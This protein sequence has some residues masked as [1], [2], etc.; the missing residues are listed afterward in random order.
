MN[1]DDKTKS[2]EKTEKDK[3]L[4]GELYYSADPELTRDRYKAKRQMWK[5]NTIT[6]LKFSKEE[7]LEE[8]MKIIK[9]WFGKVDSNVFLEPPFYCDY[10]YN[11]HMGK[12][13][14]MNHNCVILDVNTVEIGS[15]T[16][17]GPNCQLLAATHSIE[18]ES[19][20]KGLELGLPIKIGKNGWFGG[21]VIVC[22]GVTIG[23]NVTVGAGSVVT[24]D[25]PNNV[26][27]FGNPCKVMKNLPVKNE[28]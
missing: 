15:E 4:A 17:F 26:V 10:G 14:Y 6:E 2:D 13:V 5:Y 9:Q 1:K 28:L 20:I 21:G 23:D 16:M 8:R 27:A 3:M 25:I 19:R 11:I 18:P 22:P 12:Y 7:L 24:K